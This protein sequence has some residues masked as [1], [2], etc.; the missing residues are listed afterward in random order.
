MMKNTGP[1]T[2]VPTPVP[3]PAS[4]IGVDIGGTKIRAGIVGSDGQTVIA[5]TR[6]TNITGG[7]YSI[8]ASVDAVIDELLEMATTPVAGIGIS[9]AG[10]V[11]CT[12]GIIVGATPALPGWTGMALADHLTT[13][14]QLPV[15]I[16]NDGKAALVAEMWNRPELC[17]GIAVLLTLGTG[18]GGAIAVDGK[19][20]AGAGNVAG[21]FGMTGSNSG[22]GQTLEYYVSGAGLARLYDGDSLDSRAVLDKV[23]IGESMAIAARDRWVAR[24]A[25][26]IV[27]ISWII[28][29]RWLILGGGILDASESWWPALENQLA[30]I[31]ARIRPIPAALG[32]D[33]G[34]IGAACLGQ[35]AA[36]TAA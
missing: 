1:A 11:D 8:L 18:L 28:D 10:I 13:R 12:T 16:E 29:P 23:R 15:G 30:A 6:P 34:M 3:A 2:P 5:I 36:G 31:N 25:S 20:L 26:A 7:R 22:N 9:T 14:W 24:L 27:D 19:I 33:A 21:H 32:S 4:V 35:A 17:S